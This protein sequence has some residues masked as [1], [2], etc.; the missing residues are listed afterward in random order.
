MKF[1]YI[2]D[3]YLRSIPFL[4]TMKKRL[5]SFEQIY[6]VTHIYISGKNTS[7][8]YVKSFAQQCEQ[9]DITMIRSP[10][11]IPWGG[12]EATLTDEFLRLQDEDI[13]VPENGCAIFGDS[14]QMRL[15]RIYF[16]LFLMHDYTMNPDSLEDE[17]SELLHDIM[18]LHKKTNHYN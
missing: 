14:E 2:G 3:S 6:G 9:L 17:L 7:G 8:K 15:Q 11:V 12:R 5:F 18:H 4:E 13:N 16:Q 1:L 10:A